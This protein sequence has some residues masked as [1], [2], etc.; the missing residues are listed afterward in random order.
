[1]K[2]FKELNSAGR[3]IVLITHDTKIASYA[4]RVLKM[5]EGA[6][7]PDTGDQNDKD[8]NV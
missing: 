6:I 5:F 1:M 8:S 4:N 2:I 7:G 3:T